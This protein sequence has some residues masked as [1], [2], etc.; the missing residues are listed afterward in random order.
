M[1]LFGGP[2]EPEAS[3]G[4]LGSRKLNEKTLLPVLLVSFTFFI[5]TLNDPSF[6]AIIGVEPRSLAS[7][8][9][10]HQ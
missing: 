6:C 7:E 10:K 2:G 8:N 3:L 4:K 1:K 5:K 9:K